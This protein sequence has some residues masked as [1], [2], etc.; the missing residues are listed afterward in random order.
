MLQDNLKKIRTSLG[1]SQQE[2]A[3]K[4]DININTYRGYEYNKREM[5]YEIL[6]ILIITF[7]VNINW[8]LSG[9]GSMFIDKKEFSY[10]YQENCLIPQKILSF[11]NRLIFVQEKND[12]LDR[13]MAK[14]LGIYEEDYIDLKSGIREPS[15]KIINR[16]KQFF[17]ISID[18]LL[19]GD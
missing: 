5:P 6:L 19:Y 8:L 9:N 13:D 16:I 7:N 1:Y 15:F 11:N 12:F 17:N 4:L 18:W 2:M 10:K 14:I 3:D